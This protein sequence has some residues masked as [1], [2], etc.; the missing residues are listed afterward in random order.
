MLGM[1][2]FT[3][4]TLNFIILEKKNKVSSNTFM[5]RANNIVIILTMYLSVCNTAPKL[6]MFAFIEHYVL[7]LTYQPNLYAPI[8]QCNM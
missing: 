6:V 3:L 1:R 8:P 2:T 7:T 4:V 5:R